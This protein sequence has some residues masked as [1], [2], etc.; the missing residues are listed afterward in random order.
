MIHGL[1]YQ[2]NNHNLDS[3]NR[4]KEYKSL[5]QSSVE[6]EDSGGIPGHLG[7]PGSPWPA[8]ALVQVPLLILATA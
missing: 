7:V 6:A 2:Y 4:I 1:L 5:P 3:K 8:A